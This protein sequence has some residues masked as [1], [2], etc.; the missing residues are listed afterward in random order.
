MSA[1]LKRT[2]LEGCYFARITF[3]I[4]IFS[5]ISSVDCEEIPKQLIRT[6]FSIS[7]E[8]DAPSYNNCV[9]NFIPLSAY[10]SILK[11]D[12]SVA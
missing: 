5:T 2:F 9:I 11:K 6:F 10:L 8:F 1:L 3:L 4:F 7:G 12:Q